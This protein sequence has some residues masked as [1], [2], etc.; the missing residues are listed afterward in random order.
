MIFL[1][2]LKV[3]LEEKYFTWTK[4]WEKLEVDWNELKN[5]FQLAFFLS[6][7]DINEYISLLEDIKKLEESQIKVSID[8]SWVEK[9]VSDYGEELDIGLFLD[10]V[11][12]GLLSERRSWMPI[13]T[14]TLTND[15]LRYINWKRKKRNNTGKQN[16]S[17]DLESDSVVYWGQIST[18]G[19]FVE[20]SKIE[21]E[22]E[23]EVLL[24]LRLRWLSWYGGD[25][26]VLTVR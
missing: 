4:N 8:Y 16:V 14:D 13:T 15:I 19:N 22:G 2:E 20:L 5:D 3:D 9:F 26:L 21:K 6:Y 11:G 1:K 17:I 7:F 25:M 23:N 10:E 12:Y 24:K 18:D